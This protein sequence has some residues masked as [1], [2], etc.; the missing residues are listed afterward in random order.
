M[1]LL[2]DGRELE[3]ELEQAGELL[4]TVVGQ[5]LQEDTDGVFRVVR[6]V[7]KDRVIPTVDPDAPPWSEDRRP[8]V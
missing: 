3:P 7:A 8:R 5:D 2:L 1:L 4:A 6:G